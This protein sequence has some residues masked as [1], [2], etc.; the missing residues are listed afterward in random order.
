MRLANQAISIILKY[1]RE[2]PDKTQR[3]DEP[4]GNQN[5]YHTMWVQSQP[6]SFLVFCV[7]YVLVWFEFHYFQFGWGG[8]FYLFFFVCFLF[9]LKQMISF[10]FS[11]HKM[12]SGE[13]CEFLSAKQDSGL[14]RVICFHLA[15]VL[16]LQGKLLGI[17]FTWMLSVSGIICA[18]E[19]SHVA[20]VYM[21]IQ[22]TV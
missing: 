13:R 18:T 9:F 5:P 3:G 17:S 6:L 14:S 8:H 22:E 21:K 10:L 20:Y 7:V 16:Y 2:K 19:L 15:L 1:V 11:G 4:L 12:N